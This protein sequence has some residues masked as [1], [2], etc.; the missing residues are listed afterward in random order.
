MLCVGF[1]CMC[2]MHRGNEGRLKI[3]QLCCF[4]AVCH[5][6]VMK[7]GIFL[8]SSSMT[9][10]SSAGTVCRSVMLPQF[11]PRIILFFIFYFFTF[12]HYSLLTFASLLCFI[13]CNHEVKWLKICFTGQSI[14][15]RWIIKVWKCLPNR[16]LCKT[17]EVFKPLFALNRVDIYYDIILH[18]L[19]TDSSTMTINSCS[20][21]R[22]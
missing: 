13:E 19:R 21:I 10:L 7:R 18:F 4:F 11:Q 6:S 17:A 20:S 16:K 14:D 2:V 8:Q 1:Y 22:R 5:F 15:C 3:N 12:E 9:L